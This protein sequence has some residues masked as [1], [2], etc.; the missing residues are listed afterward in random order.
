MAPLA[1]DPLAYSAGV[2]PVSDRKWSMNVDGFR[3]PTRRAT[4]TVDEP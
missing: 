1:R 4:A 3:Y 2:W